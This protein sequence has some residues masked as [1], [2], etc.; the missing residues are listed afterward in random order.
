MKCS[1][2]SEK[3]VFLVPKFCKKHFID[4]FEKKVFE[5]IKKFSLVNP[6]EKIVVACSGGKDSTAVLYLLKK[7]HKK[8]VAL[9]IDEGIFGY[10]NKTLIDLKKFCSKNN[11][12]L[13]IY[14][15]EKE[16][17]KTLDEMLKQKQHPC[18][19]CGIFR[20]YLMNKYARGFGKIATGHNMDDESQAVLMNLMKGNVDLLWHSVPMTKKVGNFVQRIKPLYFCSEKEVAAY[21]LLKGFEVSFNECLYIKDSFRNQVRDALNNYELE[22]SGTKLNILKKH[23]LMLEKIKFE[24]SF[25]QYCSVC[26]E[27]AKEDIC[28]ACQLIKSFK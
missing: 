19:V 15:F 12:E 26:D 24:T 2:C 11:I 23:L 16:F 6:K 10:R 8:V 17:G 13:R 18:S 27:P 7:F 14:S 5:T 21:A 3:A 28:K 9:A 1:K 4:Y 25:F 22:N 20:R